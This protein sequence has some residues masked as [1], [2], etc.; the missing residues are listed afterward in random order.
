MMKYLRKEFTKA[1]ISAVQMDPFCHAIA[2]DGVIN[3]SRGI[4]IQVEEIALGI[5]DIIWKVARF[6]SGVMGAA[7]IFGLVLSLGRCP[8]ESE[9]GGVWVGFVG[10]VGAGWGP[11]GCSACGPP[12]TATPIWTP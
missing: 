6:D 4:V 9:S 5:F 7:D 2:D 10:G 12:P 3:I 1:Q 8:L 11:V